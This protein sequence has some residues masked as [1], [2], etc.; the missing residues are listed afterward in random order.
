MVFNE[1]VHLNADNKVLIE[2]LDGRTVRVTLDAHPVEIF[3][4]GKKISEIRVNGI[5]YLALHTF[6]KVFV[7]IEDKLHTYEISEIDQIAENCFQCH[8]MKRT[9]SSFFITPM[10]GKSRA[11]V[12]WS[13]YFVN[14]FVDESKKAIFV[15][16][17]FFHVEDYIRFEASLTKHPLFQ[18]LIDY[19]EQ[20]IAI[21]YKLPEGMEENFQLFCQG[22][23]SQMSHSYKLQVLSFHNLSQDTLIGRVL[24]KSEERKKQ[25]EMDLGVVI[26]PDVE[27]YDAPGKEEIFKKK[28]DLTLAV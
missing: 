21:Q 2:V 28:E 22:K 14:T 17:R 24:F 13:Q 1:I 5:P 12:R 15:L 26:P 25:L 16:Y 6:N 20:H 3:C 27:L 18:K 4:E 9:K 23:Y 10:L 11:D 7:M 19:D 8:T